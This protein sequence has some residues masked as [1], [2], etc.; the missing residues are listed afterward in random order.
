MDSISVK[1]FYNDVF[2][3]R[4]PTLDS[5]LDDFNNKDIGHFN[6]FNIEE[7][8]KACSNT[9]LTMPY[10]RR[11]YYKISLIGGKNRVEYADKEIVVQDYAV[12]FASPKIPYKYVPQDSE[13]KGHFCIFTKDFLAKSKS[14]LVI[15]ELPIFNTNADFVYQINETQYYELERIFEKMH[16][17]I[18]SDYTFK[19]DLLRNYVIEAIHFGQKLKPAN[20]VENSINASTRI[21]TLFIE[22]L[23]RQFPIETSTQILQLKTAKDFAETLRLHVNHLNKVLKEITGKTTTEIISS[24]ITQEAKILL[25]QTNWNVSEI[26]TSLGFEEVAHFSNFFKKQTNLSPLSYRV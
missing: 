24:R 20:S 15:D 6:V 17:E 11:T 7:M 2:G 22:L 14:G 9:K 3:G 23:E 12:L 16:S 5:F 25:K 4:C 10:N 19:Y 1:E 18:A 13:Q 8:Y 21:S 26:A